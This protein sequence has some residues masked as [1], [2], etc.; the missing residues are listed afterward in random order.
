[1]RSQRYTPAALYP[2]ERPGTHCTGGCVGPRA[3]MDRCEKP[4]PHRDSI[5]GPSSS[6]PVTI[7]TELPGPKTLK[8]TRRN[9]G[10]TGRFIMF[11]VITKIFNKKTKGPTLMELFPATGK[12]KKLFFTTTDVPCVNHGWH[13]THRYDIQV[14][15]THASTWVVDILHRRNDPCLKARISSCQKTFLVFLW[16]WTVPLS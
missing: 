2:W 8:S 9:L 14:L 12:L 13:D 3:G 6:R 10:Y 4:R 5:P 16:L 1:V 15:A 11:S 7:P